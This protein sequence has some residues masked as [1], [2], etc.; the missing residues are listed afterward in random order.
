VP[1][2]PD[3]RE[4]AAGLGLGRLDY[5]ALSPIEILGG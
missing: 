4:R 3:S 1:A 2:T 5:E